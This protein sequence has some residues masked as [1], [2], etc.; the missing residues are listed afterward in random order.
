MRVSSPFERVL[1]S[2]PDADE[3]PNFGREGVEDASGARD[4]ESEREKEEGR[5]QSVSS[6]TPWHGYT[7]AGAA[8][9]NEN[10]GRSTKSFP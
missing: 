5:E 8:P 3:A 2:F 9:T 7:A 4:R 6:Q 1:S 10:D